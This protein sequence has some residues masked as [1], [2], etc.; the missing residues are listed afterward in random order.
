MANAVQDARA[1]LGVEPVECPV[2]PA[3]PSAALRRQ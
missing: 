2:T 3:D 1:P